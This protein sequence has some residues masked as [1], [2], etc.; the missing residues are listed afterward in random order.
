MSKIRDTGKVDGCIH[1]NGVSRYEKR[2]G[3]ANKIRKT[4]KINTRYK[5]KST[6]K[7]R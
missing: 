2:S 3:T 5:F 6:N 1:K 4:L 7:I